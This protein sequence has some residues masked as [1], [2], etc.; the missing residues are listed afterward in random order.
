MEMEQK[1]SH[2][3]KENTEGDIG[4]Q[5]LPVME[6]SSLC[7]EREGFCFRC[8]VKLWLNNRGRFT[9]PAPLILEKQACC[10]M[11]I[12]R[13]TRF[14]F[15]GVYRSRKSKQSEKQYDSI[16]GELL[17]IDQCTFVDVKEQFADHAFVRGAIRTDPLENLCRL[18]FWRP[19]R[20][21]TAPL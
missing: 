4:S 18:S 19:L 14:L 13:Q 16:D 11:K 7:S 12:L 1:N 6:R 5:I 8:S 3:Q 15:S 21:R 9:H 10:K 20:R 17:Q 2:G